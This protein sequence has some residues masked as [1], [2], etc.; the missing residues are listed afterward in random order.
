[1][2]QLTVLI[3]T[4]FRYFGGGDEVGGNI[5]SERRKIRKSARNRKVDPRKKSFKKCKTSGSQN[6]TSK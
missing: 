3:I 2:S 4:I 1:M 6:A 5:I